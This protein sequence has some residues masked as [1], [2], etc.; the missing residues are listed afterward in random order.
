MKL[1]WENDDDG[2]RGQ[3]CEQWLIRD[4]ESDSRDIV[5]V[6]SKTGDEE[7]DN[8]VVYPFVADL[9]NRYNHHTRLLAALE[10]LVEFWDYGTPVYPGS[11]VVDEARKAIAKAKGE[12]A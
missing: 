12:T 8:R 3:A 6:V 4:V 10:S 5:A 7:Y 9:V 1:E 2:W 11:L